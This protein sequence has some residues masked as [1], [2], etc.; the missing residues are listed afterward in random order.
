MKKEL[1]DPCDLIEE[2]DC[3]DL[4]EK[5]EPSARTK[6]LE[7]LHYQVTALFLRVEDIVK[8]TNEGKYGKLHSSM[9]ILDCLIDFMSIVNGKNLLR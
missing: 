8:L 9:L 2:D 5:P 6:Q 4:G 3:V 1:D 7:E